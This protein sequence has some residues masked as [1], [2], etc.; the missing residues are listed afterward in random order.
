[1]DSKHALIGVE[2]FCRLLGRRL[3]TASGEDAVLVGDGADDPLGHLVLYGENVAGG[4]IPVV[5]LGPEGVAARGLDELRG[6]PNP[7]RRSTHAADDEVARSQL[8][9]DPTQ[10]VIR[11]SLVAKARVPNNHRE[12]AKA[13]EAADD[14]LGQTGAEELL[15][16]VIAQGGEGENRQRLRRR[17]IVATRFRSSRRGGG[18]M[19]ARREIADEVV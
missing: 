12:L 13:A 10:V 15:F 17:A 16:L 1:M 8:A 4:E 6:H 18:A 2:T 9:A 3:Q 5:G 7:R 14:V 11:S 19:L